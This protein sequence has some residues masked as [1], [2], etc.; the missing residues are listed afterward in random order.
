MTLIT[1]ISSLLNLGGIA[2]WTQHPIMSL[3]LTIDGLV[4]T[5]VSYAFKLFMLMCQINFD[6][7]YGIIANL[8]DNLQALIM[9]LVVFKLATE[10]IT[11]L[12][13][14]DKAMTGGKQ[15][16]IN[17]AITAAFLILYNFVFG[18]MNEISILIIGN[19]TNYSFPIL[20]RIANF[21]GGNDEGIIM[22]FMFGTGANSVEDVGDYLAVS[23]VTIFVHDLDETAGNAT[24]LKELCNKGVC[25]FHK[26]PNLVSKLDKTVEYQWG[27]SSLVG[28]FLIYSIARN[29]IEIGVR[30]FKLL[31]LQ[32]LAP[33]AIISIIKDGIKG[34]VFSNYIS[35]YLSTWAQ[36]FVRMLTML[37]VTVFVCKFYLSIG[38]FFGSNLTPDIPTVTRLLLTVIIVVAAYMFAGQIPSFIDSV[39][40]TNMAGNGGG[41]AGFGH[42]VGGLAGM[43]GGAIG[44]LAAGVTA[45]AGIA[46]T[47]GNM[48][49]GGFRGYGAGS[50]ANNVA[51]FFANNSQN[52]ANNRA[53]ARNITRAG[54]GLRY[55]FHGVE[56]ALGITAN[57]QARLDIEQDRLTA[58]QQYEE[59]INNNMGRDAAGNDFGGDM[60]AYAR[61][62]GDEAAN[63]ERERQQNGAL[64]TRLR[65]LQAQR[66]AII[67]ASNGNLT[68]ADQTALNAIYRQ[69]Q[70]TQTQINNAV[71]QARNNRITTATADWNADRVNARNSD[72]AQSALGSVDR[73]QRGAAG[74]GAEHALI[75]QQR[76][77]TNATSRAGALERERRINRGGQ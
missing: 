20:S 11:Y 55:G 60:N 16:V 44:G 9:V 41:M 75:Q 1:F 36:A 56:N 71:T 42:F 76:A 33:L 24:V 61:A 73:R 29:A 22:R 69:E 74:A 72:E 31:I 57:R 15:L 49:S 45:G 68:A 50:R 58:L 2:S 37:L 48:V 65:E 46:G 51:E 26:L 43:T 18:L 6:S 3:F 8:L 14:P 39:L 32:M 17:I 38:D 59:A 52:A 35:V 12:L 30:M 34:K 40:G 7:L 27:I 54:G 67:N 53:R 21:S 28:L 66:E 23:T 63:A 4:Y 5:L 64:G 13:D 77:R 10:L 19:D 25:N 70:A 62:R 47:F